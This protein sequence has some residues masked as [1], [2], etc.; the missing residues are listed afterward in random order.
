MITLLLSRHILIRISS[1]YRNS[2]L[3]YFYSFKFRFIHV[4]A[5]IVIKLDIV[6]KR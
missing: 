6:P 4:V 1:K 3:I 5:T 2:G